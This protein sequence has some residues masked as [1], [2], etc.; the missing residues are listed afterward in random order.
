MKP[1]FAMMKE[2]APFVELLKLPDWAE[3]SRD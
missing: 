2:E 3:P 1:G